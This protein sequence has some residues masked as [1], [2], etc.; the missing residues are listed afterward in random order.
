MQ[1]PMT[2][3]VQVYMQRRIR[4]ICKIGNIPMGVCMLTERV[5]AEPLIFFL[6]FSGFLIKHNNHPKGRLKN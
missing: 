6:I 1:V 4:Q 5:D 2:V 3:H